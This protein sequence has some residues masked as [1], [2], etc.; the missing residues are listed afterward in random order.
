MFS[1]YDY[2]MRPELKIAL[3]YLFSHKQHNAVNIISM[4][5]VGGVAVAAM[6]MVVVL[7]VFNGF[8]ELSERQLS[9]LAPP[10]Q[11]TPAQGST[12]SNCDSVSDIV[13]GIE[14]VKAVEPIV[15]Q[16]ALAAT[17]SVQ[18]PVNIMG[19]SSSFAKNARLDDVI[20]DG[21]ATS[22]EI[23]NYAIL[24]VG[25]AIDINLH[26]EEIP[27]VDIFVP[28][29]EGRINTAN[30]TASFRSDTFVPVGVYQVMQDTYDTDIVILPIDMVRRLLDLDSVTAGALNVYTPTPEKVEKTLAAALGDDFVVKTAIRQQEESFKM[31][32]IEKWVTFLMLAFILIIASFNIVSTISILIIDKRP[33]MDILRAM[34]ATPA[35]LRRIFVIQGWL[36]SVAGGIIGIIIGLA[37]S[38]LQQYCG[39]IKLTASENANLSI[40]VYPVAV[41]P[42]DIL[43]VA[44][45]ILIIGSLTA[46]VAAGTGWKKE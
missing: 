15:A 7:S 11:I 29:R 24:S 5:S 39:I 35:M 44:A 45:V 37:M 36:I 9:H 40:D 20:I 26:R 16:Q 43:V 19:V 42:T 13:Y 33:N 23:A 31:I 22:D 6:A 41:D 14:G 25:V 34:G 30:P 32:S 46:F 2:T 21:N 1:L 4:I 17:Q 12:I 28:K 8:A 3:R 10:L 18:I 27:A 38:L